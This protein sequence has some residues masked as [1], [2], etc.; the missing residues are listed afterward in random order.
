[1]KI[2]RLH[3]WHLSPKEAVRLQERLGPLLKLSPL[4]DKSIF[5]VAGADISYC[6]K[7]KVLYAGV[8]VLSFPDLRLLAETGHRQ[9]ATF[10]YVPGL[11]SFREAPPILKV[12][13][14]IKTIPQIV[15][16]D[17]QGIAH[18]RGIGLASH[19][20]LF[21]DIPTIGCAK[22][23]LVG[24][25]SEVGNRKGDFSYLVYEGQRVGAVLRT[26]NG[27]KPIFISPGHKIDID[28]A[29]KLTLACITR[30]RIPEPT[31]LAHLFVN[32]MRRQ[33]DP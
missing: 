13:A 25:F 9:K 6:Q 20:G 16:L 11:L 23:K 12:F 28:T 33:D 32:R 15:F 17:G 19:V 24:T 7:K 31:R 5:T 3:P 27:V 10:P 14:G 21:L 26:R 18:P 29:V 4:E 22:K 8:V 1:M 30:Y 2:Y